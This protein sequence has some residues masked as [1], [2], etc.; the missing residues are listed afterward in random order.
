MGYPIQLKIRFEVFL[1]DPMR[2]HAKTLTGTI[3]SLDVLDSDTIASVKAKF[4]EKGGIAYD[5]QCLI[6]EG[7]QLEDGRTLTECNIPDGGMLLLVLRM[8]GGPHMP[9]HSTVDDADDQSE[10]ASH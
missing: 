6:W 7:K 2:I 5:H 8:R 10:H 9:D 3:F 1:H 4:Q